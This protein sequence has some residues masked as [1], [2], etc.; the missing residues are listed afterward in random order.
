MDAA[1]RARPFI[2]SQTGRRLCFNQ[3]YN[4]VLGAG[5][6]AGVQLTV[7]SLRHACASHVLAGGARLEEVPR[8]SGMR[9]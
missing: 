4:V 5:R 2:A 1:R 3:V 8:F 9:G 7:H 6:L